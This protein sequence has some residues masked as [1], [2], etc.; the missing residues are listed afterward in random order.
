MIPQPQPAP[1]VAEHMLGALVSAVFIQALRDA[2][3]VYPGYGADQDAARAWLLSEDG[4]LYAWSLGVE[5]PPAAG[6][7]S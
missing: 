5:L 2:A 4:E 1:M 6:V 7:D 3:G